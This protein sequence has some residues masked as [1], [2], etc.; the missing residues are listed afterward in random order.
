MAQVAP[1]IA[2]QSAQT[3][4]VSY[5]SR[6]DLAPQQLTEEHC[7]SVQGHIDRLTQTCKDH[8]VIDQS[9][10]EAKATKEQ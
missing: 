10:T 7:A 6:T 5:S 2:D 3:R 1:A 9:A 8:P 4:Q